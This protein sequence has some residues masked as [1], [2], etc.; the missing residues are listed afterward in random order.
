MQAAE[1][2][3]DI[4]TEMYVRN[5]HFMLSMSQSECRIDF[6]SDLGLGDHTFS[7]EVEMKDTLALYHSYINRHAGELWPLFVLQ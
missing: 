5:V 2:G 4:R 6:S 1:P 7:A 3:V